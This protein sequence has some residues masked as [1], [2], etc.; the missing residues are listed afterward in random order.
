M[1][2]LVMFRSLWQFRGFMLGAVQREFQGRYQGS[3]LGGVWA[4]LNPLTMIIIYTL[5]FSQIMGARLSGHE[6]STFAY[7]IYLCA[8]LLPWTLF[9][10]V[11]ARLNS[12]FLENS[13]LIKKAQLPRAC[14]PVIVVL[15]ALLNFVIVMGLFFLFLAATDNLPGWPL[16][17]AFPLIITLQ[18]AFT[19]GLGIILGTLNV[20]F[21]DV[22]QFTGVILQFWFW[23]TPIVYIPNILSPEAQKL[24]ALNPMWPM[25][26]AYQTIF[27]E[28]RFPDGWPLVP[29]VLLSLALLLLAAKIFLA[30]VGEIVDEL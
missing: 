16:L 17:L 13:N 28:R 27:V 29:V 19:L 4:V 12:V 18:L 22:G 26:N 11:L 15:S 8:G 24:F 3:M 21:R 30:R 25:V 7:S 14:L 9:A 5:V 2:D 20:F 1:I 6:D 10:E 23:L